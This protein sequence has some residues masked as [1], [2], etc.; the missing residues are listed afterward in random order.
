MQKTLAPIV[1]SPGRSWFCKH[2][3][4]PRYDVVSAAIGC[5]RSIVALP[6]DFCRLSPARATVIV[7]EEAAAN[8]AEK[9][10]YRWIF[11]NEP[12][13]EEHR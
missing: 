3:R 9:D 11:A 5:P 10:Y 12:D 6:S 2:L 13:W 4:A 1:N 7:D 8:L